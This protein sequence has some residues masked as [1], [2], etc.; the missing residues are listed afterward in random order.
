MLSTPSISKVGSGVLLVLFSGL[1]LVVAKPGVDEPVD[2][3]GV[4][5]FER[6]IRPILISKCYD[7]HSEQ[8]EATKGGLLLDRESG[9]L[10]GGDSGK[11]VVP[12]NLQAS[13]LI[14][15]IHR[16]DEDIAMPP[17]KDDALSEREVKLLE[18]WVRRGAPGPAEDMGDTEFS[19]LGDQEYIF[20]EAAEHWAFQPVDAVEPAE[21]EHPAWN[22]SAIDRFVFAKLAGNGLSPSPRASPRDLT[23]RLAYDLTGLPPASAADYEKDTRD[24][25]DELLDSTR[26]GEHFARMWLDVARY[27]DTADTYRPDTKTPHYYPYAFTYRDYVIDAF[28]ADKPYDQFIREQLAADLMGVDKRAP[29]LAALGFIGVSPKRNMSPDFVDDVIDATTR[30]FLGMTVACSRCHDHK[31]EPIPTADYYSLYGVFGSLERAT[32]SNTG[33]FPVIDGYEPSGEQVADYEK[34]LA[35]VQKKIKDAADKKNRG[36]N[37]SL[38]T[39]IKETELAELL[40]FHDGAPARALTVKERERPIRSFIFIRGESAQRGDEVPR[41]FL[42]I[43]DPEQPDFAAENS[44]RLELADKIADPENPLTAR[45]FVNR[46]WG[47]LTGS[48]IVDTPSDFGLQGSAPSHPGLLDWLAADFVEHGWSLKHLV[49]RI[50]SSRTYQQ[51]SAVSAGVGDVDPGN[52]LYHRGK[53]KRLEIEEIRDSILAVSGQLDPRMHGRSGILLE[54]DYTTRRSIYGYINRFNLDPT[55]RAFD[56][57]SPNQSQE[58]RNESIVAPQALFTMNSPFVIDQSKALIDRLEFSDSM[59]REQRVDAIY[60][61]VLHRPAEEAE[62]VRISRF[63]DIEKGRKVNPWPLVAQAL[64]MSNEFLYVD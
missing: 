4:Q 10:E 24:Y 20:G 32:P 59:D 28:N 29:E 15:A 3:A 63:V 51:R 17:K 61:A 6:H 60:Q 22:P 58:S 11:A 21:V 26:F 27:G 8:E 38:A 30:G 50:V 39:T 5:F 23:R 7:C 35:A 45:V 31:F 12:G 44:G 33:S 46:V 37:R 62:Q 16:E 64:F 2:Q 49:R 18:Q 56:F 47:A 9:W 41:R 54:G 13:L 48:Y 40:L 57:P 34:K 19:R 42:K 25:I 1:S 14:S 52:R 43:L 36:N 55:L 53:L